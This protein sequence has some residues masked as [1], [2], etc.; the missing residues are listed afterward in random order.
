MNDRCCPCGA[1][2]DR[3]SSVRPLRSPSLRMFISIRT[4]KSLSSDRKVCNVC[5]H[6]YDKWKRENLEFS[7]ILDRL[8]ND[9]VVN[10]DDQTNDSVIFC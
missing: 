9:I 6:L 8:E 10:D 5:R 1:R 4:L 3:S 2:F 7:S